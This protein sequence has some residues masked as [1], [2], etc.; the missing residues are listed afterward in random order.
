M[1]S[2]L[3]RQLKI[4]RI[5]KMAKIRMKGSRKRSRSRNGIL[6]TDG[7]SLGIVE[8]VVRQ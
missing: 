1:L 5:N 6:A 2:S 7:P 3:Y 8:N 4:K